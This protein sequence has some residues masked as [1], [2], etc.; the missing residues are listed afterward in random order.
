M[1]F[2][3]VCKHTR[4]GPG[5]AIELG[6]SLELS[7]HGEQVQGQQPPASHDSLPRRPSS[8]CSGGV[9]KKGLTSR[10]QTAS[11]RVSVRTSRPLSPSNPFFMT[12]LDSDENDYL[13]LENMARQISRSPSPTEGRPQSGLEQYADGVEEL[14]NVKDER[15]RLRELRISEAI[16]AAQ[17]G[18]RRSVSAGSSTP[19]VPKKGIRKGQPLQIPDS[20]PWDPQ[21]VEAEGLGGYTDEGHDARWQG[22]WEPL[23]ED[24]MPRD[25]AFLSMKPMKN[26]S[27]KMGNEVVQ[28]RL[29]LPAEGKGGAQQHGEPPPALRR[30]ASALSDIQSV[31]AR[32]DAYAALPVAEDEQTANLSM[33]FLSVSRGGSPSSPKHRKTPTSTDARNLEA[34]MSDKLTQVMQGDYHEKRSRLLRNRMPEFYAEKEFKQNMLRQCKYTEMLSDEHI[35]FLASEC[36]VSKFKTSDVI[37][38]ERDKQMCMYILSV[39]EVGEYKGFPN[40]SK[41]QSVDPGL[42]KDNRVGTISSPNDTLCVLSLFLGSPAASTFAAMKSTVMLRVPASGIQPILS[43][44]HM[45]VEHMSAVLLSSGIFPVDNDGMGGKM[46]I[47]RLANQISG[48]HSNF[49]RTHPGDSWNLSPRSRA[50]QPRTTDKVFDIPAQ[51]SRE[52]QEMQPC[53]GRKDGVLKPSK[54]Q[55][56]VT[57]TPINLPENGH[58]SPRFLERDRFSGACGTRL[59]TRPLSQVAKVSRERAG[60]PRLPEGHEDWAL[61]GTVVETPVIKA[62]GTAPAPVH[63][64]LSSCG[65]TRQALEEWEKAR[66]LNGNVPVQTKM[67][68]GMRKQ[69]EIESAIKNIN[70]PFQCKIS[71]DPNEAHMMRQLQYEP[72]LAMQ[73]TAYLCGVQS[74]RKAEQQEYEEKQRLVGLKPQTVSFECETRN[75]FAS[76]DIKRMIQHPHYYSERGEEAAAKN[77]ATRDAL[78]L[79]CP[80]CVPTFSSLPPQV[81]TSDGFGIFC[82]DERLKAKFV[83]TTSDFPL[84]PTVQMYREGKY[85]LAK[86]VGILKQVEKSN[87][88]SFFSRSSSNGSSSFQRVKSTDPMNGTWNTTHRAS[89]TTGLIQSKQP[90]MAAPN[91][92]CELRQSSAYEHKKFGN[93]VRLVTKESH[94]FGDI[95][96]PDPAA[97]VPMSTLQE[98]L[99]H[100]IVAGDDER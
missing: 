44:H 95:V 19:S 15:R 100:S 3:Q 11:T 5:R 93:R 18:P 85:R 21:Q 75:N 12:S 55:L 65:T 9:L 49:A 83:A 66:D 67:G 70:T 77:M 1:G 54:P 90:D 89:E 94:A 34:T 41:I 22:N 29:L 33:N 13:N 17:L 2:A 64:I 25:Q 73:P 99:E 23:P 32:Q 63:S 46:Q 98:A 79:R 16:E 81:D 96:G 86:E 50:K 62:P 43:N 20:E 69:V 4:A 40:V 38:R 82:S 52:E 24:T 8:S 36:Q 31:A 7:V 47:M 88:G 27:G 59:S 28:K 87:S 39:G 57:R 78:E 53:V 6:R 45:L 37:V 30:T 97:Q 48:F 72:S 10:P 14:M 35:Q 51:E 84:K 74:I 76:A 92:S 60:I 68:R 61:Q 58:L 56:M 26:G 80:F 71:H 42:M 91:F